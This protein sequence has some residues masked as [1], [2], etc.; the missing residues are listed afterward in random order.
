[1]ASIV[2]GGANGVVWNSN[3]L[4]KAALAAKSDNITSNGSVVTL[5]ACQFN[6]KN[7]S[8]PSFSDVTG[9][10]EFILAV[11]LSSNTQEY[12]AVT[13]AG[14]FGANITVNSGVY[15]WSDDVTI[16][17][18]NISG[19]SI[20]NNGI[21][22][23]KGGYGGSTGG[24][25]GSV[26]SGQSGGPAI[27]ISGSGVTITN[28]SG[29]YIAGGG[30]GGGRGHNNAGGGGGAGGGYGGAGRNG[31]T[32]AST[33]QSTP[34]TPG[35]SSSDTQ[36]WA[37]SGGGYP[38][39][40]G[41]GGGGGG[42]YYSN[43]GHAGASGGRIV[44]GS[45]SDSNYPYLGNGGAGG[46][47]NGAGSNGSGTNAGGGGGGWGSSGG[48]GTGGNGGGASGKAVEN[49]G[50]TYTLTNNGTVYGST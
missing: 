33:P 17:A 49:N 39:G 15:V 35:N 19:G 6:N 22:I 31:D 27:S 2:I 30:G 47:A 34:G 40:A 50:N 44:P 12:D 42:A 26:A 7:T 8:N 46:S 13:S 32:Q 20:T 10:K 48:T 16:P 38:P 36:A 1:M 24:V 21:I 29:A 3:T 11:T 45:G 43:S 28:N 14:L 4:T 18:I 25:Q 37:Y 5:N 23:G 9:V 41:A